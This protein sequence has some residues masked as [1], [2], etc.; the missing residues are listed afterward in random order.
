MTTLKTPQ[1]TVTRPSRNANPVAS[2][3]HVSLIRGD[4]TRA[5][6]PIPNGTAY[7]MATPDTNQLLHSR[8][9]LYGSRQRP[10]TGM[11][12]LGGSVGPELTGV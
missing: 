12:A 1:K 6:H 3:E 2:T 4:D 8:G 7:G 9:G 5:V 11:R 10:R